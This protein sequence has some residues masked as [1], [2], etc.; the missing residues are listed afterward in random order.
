M[1]LSKKSALLALVVASVSV[2]AGCPAPNG[3]SPDGAWNEKYFIKSVNE[4]D[5]ALRVP[6]GVPCQP[7]TYFEQ[8]RYEES[9]WRRDPETGDLEPSTCTVYRPVERKR[10]RVSRRYALSGTFTYCERRNPGVCALQSFSTDDVGAT[11]KLYAN[12]F[13]VSADAAIN[14]A[15]RIEYVKNVVSSNNESS[16]MTF[17]FES[18]VS[19]AISFRAYVSTSGKIFDGAPESLI[20]MTKGVD[21]AVF[22]LA[23]GAS[24]GIMTS[25]PPQ[26]SAGAPP[27]NNGGAVVTD[28][29][30]KP[31]SNGPPPGSTTDQLFKSSAE[32]MGVKLTDKA[33]KSG[34]YQLKNAR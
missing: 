33:V 4:K 29:S 32:R 17:D 11:R 25:T 2:L 24:S 28:P 7:E 19:R 10:N 27:A 13:V 23:C 26:G 8:V 30:G 31:V 15:D 12:N 34:M 9:C 20:A 1:A 6:D 14:L 18:S 5:L 22:M 21:N 3:V 16:M